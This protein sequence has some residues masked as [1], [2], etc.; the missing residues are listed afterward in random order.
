MYI[1]T[2]LIPGRLSHACIARCPIPPSQTCSREPHLTHIRVQDKRNLGASSRWLAGS[3]CPVA[4]SVGRRLGVLVGL[5]THKHGGRGR[6]VGLVW[7]RRVCEVPVAPVDHDVR[8]D[9]KIGTELLGLPQQPEASLAKA[10]S[11]L[12][13]FCRPS[14]V[15]VGLACIARWLGVYQWRMPVRGFG[16]FA[17]QHQTARVEGSIRGVGI[18]TMRLVGL[19]LLPGGRAPSCYPRLV[20]HINTDFDRF[21]QMKARQRVAS[22]KMPQRDRPR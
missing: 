1:T 16:G 21:A 9:A 4:G 3:A 14:G 6:P 10:F 8:L 5:A 13:P 17:R 2:R 7:Q 15:G 11:L 18:T 12:P 20:R 22:I 19:G